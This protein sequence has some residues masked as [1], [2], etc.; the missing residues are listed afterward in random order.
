MDLTKL[1]KLNQ[2]AQ[3]K[4]ENLPVKKLSDLELNKNHKLTALKQVKTRFGD[5]VVANIEDSYSV[6]LPA[7]LTAIVGDQL[8]QEL[9]EAV[10]QGRLYLLYEG[11]SFNACQFIYE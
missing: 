8:L 4:S 11:G 10:N 7:R 3:L 1:A 6:F 9:T 2:V 5:R